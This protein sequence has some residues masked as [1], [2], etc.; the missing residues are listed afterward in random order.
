MVGKNSCRE[1]HL[2]VISRFR[3]LTLLAE[4]SLSPGAGCVV[5]DRLPGNNDNILSGRFS[6]CFAELLWGLK[7]AVYRRILPDESSGKV[8]GAEVISDLKPGVEDA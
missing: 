8:T 2:C 6:R 7:E 4:D 1:W 3:L 5:Q